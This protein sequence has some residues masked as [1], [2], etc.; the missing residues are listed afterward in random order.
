MKRTLLTSLIILCTTLFFTACKKDDNNNSNG[1]AE[2]LR[3]TL[4]SGTWRVTYYFDD[5][6]RTINLS[7]YKFTFANA[8]LLTASN[9]IRSVNGQWSTGTDDSSTK[10]NIFFNTGD[11]LAEISEDWILL[12]RTGTKVR[13]QHGSG[14]DTDLLTFERN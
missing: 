11:D 7:A 12:E 14:N 4:Q 10:L 5:S 9:D 13:L 3:G 8:G 6:D 1:S 2:S